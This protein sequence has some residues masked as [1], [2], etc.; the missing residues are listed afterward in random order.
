MKILKECVNNEITHFGITLEQQL[1]SLRTKIFKHK[2]SSSHKTA[3]KILE[4]A[5]KETLEKVC[6]KSLSSQEEVTAKIFLTAYKVAKSNQSFNNFEVEI[7]FQ[8]HNGVDMERILHYTNACINI[9]NHISK[10]I[11]K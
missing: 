3:I 5:K 11:K 9:I 7:E 10:E 8:E 6:L 4:E 2:E 1:T